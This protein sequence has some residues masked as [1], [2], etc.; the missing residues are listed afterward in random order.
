[1]F[2]VP[3]S[4]HTCDVDKCS[5]MAAFDLIES[6][7]IYVKVDSCHCLCTGPLRIESSLDAI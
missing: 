1:M 7:L 6:K 2:P 4:W 5:T 3:V